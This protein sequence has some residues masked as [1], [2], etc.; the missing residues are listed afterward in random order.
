MNEPRVR[1]L[2]LLH[3]IREGTARGQLPCQFEPSRPSLA[4][5][6]LGKHRPSALQPHV[7]GFTP[8]EAG[9]APPPLAHRRY[10]P[11]PISGRWR[12]LKQSVRPTQCVG[13]IPILNSR[14][15]PVR[16]QSRFLT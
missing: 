14:A 16:S 11:R 12:I 8:T 13:T 1:S 5:L 10:P 9:A 15:S 6:G 2:A 4:A 7:G 3:Y